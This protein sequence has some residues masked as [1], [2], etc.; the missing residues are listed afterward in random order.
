VPEW[1][2][3]PN[4]SLD[5]ASAQPFGRQ[6]STESEHPRSIFAEMRVM[7]ATSL[8]NIEDLPVFTGSESGAA[9]HTCD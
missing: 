2:N 5:F 6:F 7:G 3:A 4:H 1:V 9:V 8:A